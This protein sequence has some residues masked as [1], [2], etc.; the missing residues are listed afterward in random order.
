MTNVAKHI[1]FN[2]IWQQIDKTTWLVP[3]P[4][5]ILIKNDDF[6]FILSSCVRRH[7]ACSIPGQNAAQRL[8][9]LQ[10]QCNR[11]DR[12]QHERTV[13]VLR[14]VEDNKRFSYTYDFDTKFKNKTKKNVLWRGSTRQ[15]HYDHYLFNEKFIL[16][17]PSFMG[18]TVCNFELFFCVKNLPIQLDWMVKIHKVRTLTWHENVIDDWQHQKVIQTIMKQVTQY[19]RT[20]R[21]VLQIVMTHMTDQ[22]NNPVT[23]IQRLKTR[24]IKTTYILRHLVERSDIPHRPT[25]IASFAPWSDD[26]ISKHTDGENPGVNYPK[27][28]DPNTLNTGVYAVRTPH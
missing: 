14:I 5:L 15:R 19:E 22:R 13:Y 21:P 2:Y 6:V 23:D 9:T 4:S 12:T 18:A 7:S 10:Y 17:S 3:S 28:Q 16:L 11:A 1:D 8:C 27:R 25:T 20:T 26:C 24:S